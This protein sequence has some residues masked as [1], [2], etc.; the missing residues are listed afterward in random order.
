LINGFCGAGGSPV[1]TSAFCCL[2]LLVK[3]NIVFRYL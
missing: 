3:F 1:S 2:R